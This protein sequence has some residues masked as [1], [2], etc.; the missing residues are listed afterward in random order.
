[1]KRHCFQI[2]VILA[3]LL[4]PSLLGAQSLSKTD[5]AAIRTIVTAVPEALDRKDM[6]MYADLF[7]DDADWVNVVG[8]H[9]RGKAAV[10]KAHQAYLKTVFRDGGMSTGE[11]SIRPVTSDV[12]I[13][14]V[15]EIN[16]GGGILP[17]GS[18]APPGSGRLTYVL[19]K[20]GGVWK[21]THGHNTTID[22]NAQ[23][24]DPVNGDRTGE[25]PKP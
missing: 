25:A 1:M 10:V 6:K 9:W 7:A 20:R 8:M 4:C 24:F 21:I 13:V 11:M 22:P 2:G 16:R 5:E 17:D 18:K 14:V 23:R 15:T 3:G 19:V 12:A